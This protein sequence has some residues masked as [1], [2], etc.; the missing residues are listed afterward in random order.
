MLKAALKNTR[1]CAQSTVSMCGVFWIAILYPLQVAW[2]SV[3][4]VL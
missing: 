3:I 4:I 2:D 1:F